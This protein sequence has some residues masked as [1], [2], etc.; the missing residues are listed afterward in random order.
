MTDSQIFQELKA[1]A[2]KYINS[3]GFRAKGYSFYTNDYEVSLDI[4]KKMK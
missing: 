2:L 1:L 4:K 3:P